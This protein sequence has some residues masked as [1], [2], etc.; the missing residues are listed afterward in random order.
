[1]VRFVGVPEVVAAGIERIGRVAGGIE[2]GDRMHDRVAR[3][4][5]ARDVIFQLA[6]MEGEIVLLLL[7]ER[8]AANDD[9]PMVE[10]RLADLADESGAWPLRQIDAADFNPARRR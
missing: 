10:Q 8:L 2:I 1:V 6:E 3:V 4:D 9:N 7:R 5:V